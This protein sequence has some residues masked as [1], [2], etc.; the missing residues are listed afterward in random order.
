MFKIPISVITVI[1]LIGLHF[2]ANAQDEGEQFFN[3]ICIACHT[4]GDGKLLGPDLENVHKR[5]SEE[6]M[7]KFIRSSQMMIKEGDEKAVKLFNE[8]NMIVMPDNAFTD[9]QIKS[10]IAYIKSKSGVEETAKGEETKTTTIIDQQK[11]A[12][13]SVTASKTQIQTTDSKPVTI[14]YETGEQLF[15][16]NCTACHAIGKGTLVGP[17]LKG[18]NS[19]HQEEWLLKFIKSSQTMIQSGDGEAMAVY[20]Q[21]NE[22]VMPDQTLTNDEIR[23]ILIYISNYK[24]TAS[25]E[26]TEIK[27]KGLADPSLDEKKQ[28]GS[29]LKA[30][31]A[32]PVIVIVLISILL[33]IIAR[34]SYTLILLLRMLKR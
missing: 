21:F 30:F 18:I 7:I 8:N 6:W 15:D 11:Q 5:H 33:V 13:S 22:I 3:T 24:E 10:I 31:L 2:K 14:S 12:P 28:G 4:I 9:E 16:Q 27:T 29:D 25:I 34:L 32:N 26:T 23:A 20:K 19:K 1:L 17:D